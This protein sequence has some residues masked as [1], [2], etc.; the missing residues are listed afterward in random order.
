MNEVSDDQVAVEVTIL[1]DAG[2]YD[3]IEY[4]PKSRIQGLADQLETVD[5]I[6]ARHRRRRRF[7]LLMAAGGL[8]V[9]G[10]GARAAFKARP[11]SR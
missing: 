11:W 10:I 9:A 5:W 8:I 7:A 1:T 3:A 2:G 6:H 4:W